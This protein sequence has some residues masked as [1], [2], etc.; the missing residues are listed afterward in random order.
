[1]YLYWRIQQDLSCIGENIQFHDPAIINALHKWVRKNFN[2][3]SMV[4]NLNSNDYSIVTGSF[5]YNL[6]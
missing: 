6:N 5:S 4:E 2:R 3:L 1:M